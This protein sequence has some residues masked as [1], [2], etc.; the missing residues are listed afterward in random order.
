MHKLAIIDLGS[1]SVRMIIMRIDPSGAYKMIEQAKVMVRLSQGTGETGELQPEPIERTIETL[2]LFQHL[3]EVHGTDRA[4]PVATAAVRDA[5]NQ[6]AF[7]ERV[8][9]E[10]GLD[11]TVLT[12]DEEAGYDYFGV[13]N[14]L[15]LQDFLLIDTGGGSTELALVKNGDLRETVSLR[16]GAVTLTESFFPDYE[17]TPEARRQALSQIRTELLALPW[18]DEAEGLPI[19]GVGGTLR[20]LAK[21]D[22]YRLRLPLDRIHGYTLSNEEVFDMIDEILSLP[23]K[24]RRKIKGISSDRAEVIAGGLLPLRAL[25]DVVESPVFLV[26][27]SGLR[28]GL[29]HE[30]LQEQFPDDRPLLERS[31]SNLA[32]RYEVNE[33]H[34]AHVHHLSSRLLS[35]LRHDGGFFDNSDEL[36]LAA[37]TLH[38]TGMFV[39][40]YDHHKH[41]FYLTLNS[42]L[43][44]LS[45]EDLVKV[46]FMVGRH[47]PDRKLRE[48]WRQYRHYLDQD[49]YQKVKRLATL[50]MVAEKLDRSENSVVQDIAVKIKKKSVILTLKTD[51]AVPL[52]KAAAMN[53]ATAFKKAFGKRLIIRERS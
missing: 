1:N 34:S 49:S 17:V 27:G 24:K 20:S 50:L 12:G 45:H 33:S 13:V 9:S 51:Q 47:R 37:A 11:F 46:A 42:D 25:L 31:L 8:K 16:L 30:V 7:L 14:T 40:Y 39:D 18:L 21:I 48:N 36:L 2:H 15:P 28:E 52:E 26:S 19:V 22:K 3:M 38:D 4:I 32:K 29:F 43:D 35:A 53:A 41:S 6:A 23:L 44:G 10:T 5:T